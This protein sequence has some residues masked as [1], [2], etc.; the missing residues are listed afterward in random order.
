MKSMYWLAALAATSCASQ[1]QMHVPT[2][3]TFTQAQSQPEPA[4]ETMEIWNGSCL[5]RA[6]RK[7]TDGEYAQA[8]AMLNQIC[9]PY[10]AEEACSGAIDRMLSKSHALFN[11]SLALTYLDHGCRGY[12]SQVETCRRA[13]SIQ[14][15]GIEP[16]YKMRLQAPRDWQGWGV[17]PNP[18]K[19]VG[20]LARA[21]DL[22]DRDACQHV[23][24]EYASG[25]NVRRDPKRAYQLYRQLCYEGDA[26]ACDEAYKLQV[27]E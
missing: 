24:M 3:E 12:R 11:P 16:S 6:T 23:A 8:E 25:R 14:A 2:V 10:S 1:S 4:C 5:S 13:A 26:Y 22:G 21:C 18:V 17:R 15:N 19:A 20:S 9:G 27:L 7:A